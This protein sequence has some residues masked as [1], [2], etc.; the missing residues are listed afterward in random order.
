LWLERSHVVVDA[1]DSTDVGNN[2]RPGDGGIAT[3]LAA[4]VEEDPVE[5]PVMSDVV[6]LDQPA[7][8]Y[9][10]LMYADTDDQELT[11]D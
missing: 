11:L 2:I 7:R 8:D 6:I 3:A 9:V 5:R 1:G 4:F 10:R